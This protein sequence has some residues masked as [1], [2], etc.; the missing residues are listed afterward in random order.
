MQDSG[1]GDDDDRIAPNWRLDFKIN[2]F[3]SSILF[4]F[5][6]FKP[7][8]ILLC[9]SSKISRPNLHSSQI[10]LSVSSSSLGFCELITVVVIQSIQGSL[11]QKIKVASLEIKT[12]PMLTTKLEPTSYQ[13]SEYS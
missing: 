5:F 11:N 3:I 10:W 4:L 9:V 8:V 6:S 12:I 7:I 1:G 13:K 2:I